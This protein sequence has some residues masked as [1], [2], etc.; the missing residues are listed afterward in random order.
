MVDDIH[1]DPRPVI[2]VCAVGL[3]DIHAETDY[4]EGDDYVIV[5]D[6]MVCE[7]CWYKYFRILQERQKGLG[8]I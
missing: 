7:D 8:I 6:E 5:D 3:H 4:Y 1:D 2:G